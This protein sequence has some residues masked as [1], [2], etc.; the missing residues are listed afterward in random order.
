MAM[1]HALI[2]ILVSHGLFNI[3]LIDQHRWSLHGIDGGRQIVALRNTWQ[4]RELSA[5]DQIVGRH[6]YASENS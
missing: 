5:L 3:D 6:H 1:V 2:Q 4:A